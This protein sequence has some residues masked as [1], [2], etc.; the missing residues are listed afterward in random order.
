[1]QERR[2]ETFGQLFAVVMDPIFKAATEVKTKLAS[3][4][5]DETVTGI[6]KNAKTKKEDVSEAL[7]T[8]VRGDG[9]K[10]LVLV[11]SK[12]DT[13]VNEAKRFCPKV[14]ALAAD[15]PKW[16]DE[17]LGPMKEAKE[18]MKTCGALQAACKRIKGDENRRDMVQKAAANFPTKMTPELLGWVNGFL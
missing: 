15:L 18:L 10:A 17:Y 14:I 11:I 2:Q 3:L 4:K 7:L 16:K 8:F 13:T 5:F 12:Y 1:M 9:T 6:I